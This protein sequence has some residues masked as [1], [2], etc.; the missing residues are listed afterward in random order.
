MRA[1][2]MPSTSAVKDS[3][4]SNHDRVSFSINSSGS[5]QSDELQMSSQ[6][7]PPSSSSH[8]ADPDCQDP[9]YITFSDYKPDLHGR[10]I[11]EAMQVLYV[12]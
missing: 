8:S 11:K 3:V 10:A 6:H 7:P 4:S 9:H 2:A 5:F 12:H 1:T